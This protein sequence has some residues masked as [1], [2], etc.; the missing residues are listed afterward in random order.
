M[1]YKL[2]PT[3]IRYHVM[4]LERLRIN[5]AA[6]DIVVASPDDLEP[7][8][9]SQSFDRELIRMIGRYGLDTSDCLILM[10]AA[11]LAV[12]SIVT[13]GRDL[14]RAREDIDLYTWE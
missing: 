14:L 13:M 5:L 10:E 1:L 11:R 3:I 9:A 12:R 6:I 8:P 7:I 2:D 4:E